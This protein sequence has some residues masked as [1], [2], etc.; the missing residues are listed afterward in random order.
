MRHFLILS[1]SYLLVACLALFLGSALISTGPSSSL[2]AGAVVRAKSGA[3]IKER[4][5]EADSLLTGGVIS[6]KEHERLRGRLIE[7]YAADPSGVALVQ[8]KTESA[9]AGRNSIPTEKPPSKPLLLIS[10]DGVASSARTAAMAFACALGEAIQSGQSDWRVVVGDAGRDGEAHR[11][12]LKLV[13]HHVS[14]RPVHFY[15]SETD[16]GVG[17]ILYL[18]LNYNLELAGLERSLTGGIR[19]KYQGNDLVPPR[20]V[21]LL[22]FRILSSLPGRTSSV[23]GLATPP[24]SPASATPKSEGENIESIHDSGFLELLRKKGLGQDQ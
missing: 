14:S 18:N 6:R 15:D 11:G 23:S 7:I 19:G 2:A 5:A 20:P 13:F 24:F 17:R 12:I 4:L 1:P 9:G 22:A 10:C 21:N 8:L 3:T 16:M